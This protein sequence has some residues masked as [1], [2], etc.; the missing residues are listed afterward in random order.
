VAKTNTAVTEGNVRQKEW[1]REAGRTNTKL[2]GGR[3]SIL[4]R[5]KD[6]GGLLIWE[7]G[8]HEVEEALG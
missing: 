2:R 5:K 6:K 7:K 1:I 4:H 3:T 8:K